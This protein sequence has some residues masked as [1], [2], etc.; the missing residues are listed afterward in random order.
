[1]LGCEVNE[2]RKVLVT[3]IGRS[4]PANLASCNSRPTCAPKIKV[5]GS[6]INHSLLILK[7]TLARPGS[8]GKHSKNARSDGAKNRHNNRAAMIA[9]CSASAGKLVASDGALD[10]PLS[11]LSDG[12]TTAGIRGFT[13]AQQQDEENRTGS[14]FRAG[15]RLFARLRRLAG[16][17]LVADRSCVG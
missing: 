5:Y 3:R 4:T 1:M 13:A 16:G 17:E 9:S 15:A 8:V 7:I 12:V 6:T 2:F 11:A 14:V 10:S